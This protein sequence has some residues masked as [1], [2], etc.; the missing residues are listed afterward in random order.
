MRFKPLQLFGVIFTF[1]AA[2]IVAGG[3]YLW[4]SLESIEVGL[5][6]EE[7]Q[8]HRSLSNTIESLSNLAAN[9]DALRVEAS[10]ERHEDMLLALDVAYSLTQQF[11]KN[12]PAD[13]EKLAV[14]TNEALATLDMMEEEIEGVA[15][16]DAQQL[17]AIHTRLHD[18][19]A[20][21][22]ESYLRA[23]DKAVGSLTHQVNQV[24][25]LRESTLITTALITLALLGMFWL[26]WL[27]KQTIMLLSRMETELKLARDEA[28][29]ANRA[30]SDFL[31]SMSHEIRTPM[32]AILGMLYLTLK[33]D[34]NPIQYNYLNKVQSAAKSLLGIIN[35]ILDF[36]RIESGQLDVD[37]VEFELETVLEQLTDVVGHRAEQR[38]IEFLVRQSTNLPHTL[39]GD[40]VR[41]GQIL[42]N[43]CGN[44]VKFTEQGEVELSIS[45]DELDEDEVVLKF[46]VRDSGMG[47]SD[48][49]KGKLFR[50]FS[51]A[52]QSISRRYGGTGL[53]LAISSQL[54]HLM[55]G[56]IWLDKSELGIGSTF[57]FSLP[58]A[59]S[60][61]GE[62]SHRRL[63]AELLPR[64]KGLRALIV[65]DNL[66]ARE[67]HREMMEEFNFEV[68]TVNS[69]EEALAELLSPENK[70][71]YDIVLMDWKMPGMHGDEATV[72]IHRDVAIQPKPKVIMVTSYG[73]D[74]VLRVAEQAGVDGFLLKP[75]SPSTLLDAVMA[76]LGHKIGRPKPQP[77]GS[78][79]E[80]ITSF[81]GTKCLLVEDNEVNREFATELLVSLDV[82]VDHAHNG[83]VAL[84]RVQQHRYDL[85]LMD[86]QMP[87][88]DGYEATRRI[89][90][91]A[92]QPNGERYAS[93]PI[94]ALTAQALVDDRERALSA[95]MSDY[96]PKPIDPAQLITLIKEWLGSGESSAE[97]EVFTVG[98]CT[99]NMLSDD[100]KSLESIDT[101]QGLRRM[102]CN[103]V[104]YR[105]ML[106]RFHE[107][108]ANSAKG[109]RDLIGQGHLVEAE[110]LCHAFKGVVGNIGADRLFEVAV[111]IDDFLKREEQPPEEQLQRFEELLQ[112]LVNDIATILPEEEGGEMVGDVIVDRIK[113]LTLLAELEVAIDDD[114]MVALRLLEEL[115]ALADESEWAELIKQISQRVGEFDSD[116]AKLLIKR[117]EDR[118]V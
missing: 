112:Q 31:A 2:I 60:Y 67:V 1:F 4:L 116:A 74:E 9:L 17:L 29:E 42:I 113:M 104:A 66:V 83:K 30:K 101:L 7:L 62:M 98:A 115:M 26:A 47:I 102:A 80:T 19:L 79:E 73:R 77:E 12:I 15:T 64:L 6:V 54:S 53:G 95:G 25:K 18:V 27:Q 111:E 78:R 41:L 24:A 90:A 114:L 93:L 46:C 103:E 71:G 55:K 92:E 61:Q 33:T 13:D 117:L 68:R 109:L 16:V 99:E 57:C 105:K 22:T 28:E 58:F 8:Q 82:E 75:V 85:V 86:I 5:P 43:L 21:Y 11:H 37:Y 48:E 40:P 50:K 44:G 91:L 70:R 59:V 69:G 87:V 35:D 81:R 51:Q 118:L 49:Q 84:A 32:N 39:V 63:L 88:M 38:G 52:D 89:R 76:A 107:H 14:V 110:G 23:N 96:I 45:I 65:D 97:S 108:Y 106:F 10:P 100:L 3:G 20:A 34:L 36:S 56:Q 94:I 72:R